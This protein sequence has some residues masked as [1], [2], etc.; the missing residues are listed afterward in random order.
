MALV[1]PTADLRGGL[2]ALRRRIQA[3]FAVSGAA[4]V[5]V[6]L[7]LALGLFYAADLFLDLPLGV[8][9]FVRLG[10]LDRHPELPL[11]LWL[12]LTVLLGLCAFFLTRGARAGAAF[13][14]FLFAG[15]AGLL[16]SILW[17]ACA[18]LSARLSDAELAALVERRHAR[19]GDRLESALDFERELGALQTNSI[20]RG[21]SP[22]MMRSVLEQ[23]QADAR[24]VAFGRVVSGRA[25]LAWLGTAALTL[26]GAG[27]ALGLSPD[28]AGLFARRSLLLEDTPWP[29]AST[30]WAATLGADGR[31]RRWPPETPFQVAVGRSLVVEAW[32]EGEPVSEALLLDLAEGQ[33]P[34]PRRMF[35]VAG[36]PGFYAVELV[37]VRQGFTFVLQGGDDRD[38]IPVYRVEAT[39]P[40]ALLE[41]SAALV[42]PPY[43]RR[44][45]ERVEGGNLSVPQGT[46]I[47]FLFVP[48]EPLAELRALVGEQVLAGERVAADGAGE[49]WRVS[50]TAE[51][52]LRLRLLLRAA[53]GRENDAAADAYDLTVLEDRAPKVEWLWPHGATEVTPTGRVPLLLRT[54]DDHAVTSL[55]LELRVGAEGP[56]TKVALRPHTPEAPAGQVL[57]PGAPPHGALMP[58]AVMPGAV[59]E[60]AGVDTERALA[61]NDGPDGRSEI[62]TYV[63]LELGWLAPEGGL[64]APTTVSVRVTAVDSKGQQRESSWQVLDVYAP[65]EL[66]R[67]LATRRSGVKSAVQSLEAEQLARLAQVTELRQGPVGAGERDLLKSV[68]FAQA[69]LEQ[70]ADSAVRD[71]LDIFAH[72]V[73]DRLGAENPNERI[74]AAFDRH[75][76]STYGRVAAGRTA[77]RQAEDSVFPYE[78]FEEVV[79]AWRERRLIDSGLLERMLA[80]LEAGLT[81]A[82]SR[83]PEAHR[84]AT[85]AAGGGAAEIEALEAAQRAHLDALRR[86]LETMASWESL[87]DVIVRLKRIVEEQKA[88]LDQLDAA[89]PV[90]ASKKPP[91]SP[92]PS[93]R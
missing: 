42:F 52:S 68:E 11:L 91:G 66:E 93:P 8:R 55:T 44:A 20:G 73:L 46:L 17:R 21:E 79:V 6:A 56:V 22:A 69:K 47:S 36:R 70:H 74:L 38:E 27:A 62:L 82:A 32:A 57:W 81:T 64:P 75:H 24:A 51:R 90:D 3:F 25:T 45:P 9:R 10:L 29:R 67:T 13:V 80:V 63:P 43:L 49:A 76:R 78:L 18:P 71:Y 12:P 84:A 53:D 37:N 50:L 35:P 92:M 39:V 15:L 61:A 31:V 7:L 88:L 5:V 33:Q 2:A 65:A 87:N 4:R 41:I 16:A 34:L 1:S 59:L 14:A 89:A 54:N 23:A 28:K 19:L 40:P 77:P 86:L 85:R 58:G 60:G 72:F 83:A 26:V 30:L 48:S